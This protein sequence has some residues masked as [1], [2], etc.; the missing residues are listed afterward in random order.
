MLP[1]ALSCLDGAT[2]DRLLAD[3][4]ALHSDHQRDAG[5]TLM[6]AYDQGTYSKVWSACTV[7]LTGALQT[8]P[9]VP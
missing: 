6:M 5:D 7:T 1:V 2:A 3:T 4:I 8:E 9:S